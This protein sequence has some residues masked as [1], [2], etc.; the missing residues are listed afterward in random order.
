MG[1][2]VLHEETS[3][4]GFG[5]ISSDVDKPAGNRIDHHDQESYMPEG[6]IV[7]PNV[8]E[9]EAEKGGKSHHED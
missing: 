6:D 3:G 1:L 4:D 9:D 2:E 7:Q 5:H 8:G